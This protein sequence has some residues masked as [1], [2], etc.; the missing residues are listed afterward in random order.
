MSGA[1]QH[2]YF[3][4]ERDAEDV[5]NITWPSF[6]ALCQQRF[7]PALGTNHLSDLARL[8]F[9][10]TVVGYVE[11]FL[12]RMAHA[13]SLSPLQHVQLFTGG[14]PDPIR[15]DVELQAPADLQRAM[16]LA[17]AYER[18]AVAHPGA[19]PVRAQRP[20]PRPQPL[21]LPSPPIASPTPAP[22]TTTI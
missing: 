12:S 16:G 10:G 19:G 4:L 14:L 17:R 11:A 13:G 1:A 3:M 15:T 6:K 9:P 2:W 22:A 7:G 5:S 20:A 21:P 18:R 8:P